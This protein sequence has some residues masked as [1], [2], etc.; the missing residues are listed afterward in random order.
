M[1][2]STKLS[3]MGEQALEYA[4]LGWYVVPV[5]SVQGKC[6]SCNKKE[7]CGNSAG[8]HP[9]ISNW[10]N[11]ASNDPREIK[12]WWRK[13]PDANV[14]I[15]TG[16]KSG[17]VVVDADVKDNGLETIR[18]LATDHPE[19]MNTYIV[20]TGGGGLHLYFRHPGVE[21]KN[22]VRFAPGLDIRADNG[23]VIAPPSIHRSGQ[24]YEARNTPY[25]SELPD[26]PSFVLDSHSSRTRSNTGTTHESPKNNISKKTSSG[27]KRAVSVKAQP[28]DLNKLTADQ[29]RDIR[30]AMVSSMPTRAGRRNQQTFALARR[31]HS[32]PGVEWKD[33]N[34]ESLRVLVMKWHEQSVAAAKQSGFHIDATKQETWHDFVYGWDR[35]KVPFGASL[36]GVVETVSKHKI[37]RGGKPP[38]PVQNAADFLMYDDDQDLLLLMTFMWELNEFHEGLGFFLSAR[39]AA[40][41]I[42]ELGTVKPRDHGW[43]NRKMNQL[44]EDRV[45]QCLERGD[46]GTEGHRK[47]S[48]Y[49][50]IWQPKTRDA[51]LSWLDQ[52]PTVAPPDATAADLDRARAEQL[53]ALA[54]F[55]KK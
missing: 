45:L 25:L 15:V 18:S 36:E 20:I 30:E 53:K 39:E 11:K 34:V 42:R 8:K 37:G 49:L 35:V 43:T 32:V 46:A 54:N 4:T 27:L 22:R 21:V 28:L 47:S 2:T 26:L 33:I 12:R 38:E 7:N 41:R 55:G 40:K 24:V 10:Q 5:N 13:W 50:W 16:P 19:L 29:Q 48:T 1:N 17:L 9:R 31:L 14:G 3:R 23:L 6:C 44:E 52:T 51:D